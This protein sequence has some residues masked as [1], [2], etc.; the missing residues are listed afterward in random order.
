MNRIERP[1]AG[2]LYL[3]LGGAGACLLAWHVTRNWEYFSLPA[4][5]RPGHQAHPRLRSSGDLGLLCGIV[6]SGLFLLNLTYL[7]RKRVAAI[8]W[9]GSLRS[10]MSFHLLTGLA[11]CGFVLL[12][13]AFLPRSSLGILALASLGIVAATGLV[14]RYIY[15]SVP[16]SLQGRELEIEEL[17]KRLEDHRAQLEACGLSVIGATPEPVPSARSIPARFAI[18]LAGSRA[19]RREYRRLRAAVLTHPGLKPLAGQILPLARKYSA[20]RQ[21][22]TRYTEL[23]GLMGSWRFLHRWLAILMLTV[24]LFHVLVALRFGDLV[25]PGGPLP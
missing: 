25:F 1:L 7:L 23:R 15:A 20:D 10:W 8:R 19:V 3:M 14:G 9:L 12:H 21:W 17:R 16:R 6:A 24:V 13:S 11:G 22:L 2:R 5:S 4:V 18:L